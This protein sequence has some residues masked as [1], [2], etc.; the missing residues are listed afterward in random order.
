MPEAVFARGGEFDDEPEPWYKQHWAGLRNGI[1]V[2]SWFL[3]GV[4]VTMKVAGW[5][6]VTACYV[7]TQIVTTIGYGDMAIPEDLH[8]FMTIY[9][10][11][12]IAIVA[13]VVNDIFNSI[14]EKGTERMRAKLRKFESQALMEDSDG[15]DVDVKEVYGA[16]NYFVASFLFFLFFLILGATFY[17]YYESCTCS[18][19]VST[20][21]GCI[22]GELC[23]TT[24]GSTKNWSEC[25]YMAV[26]TMVTVGFGDYSPTSWGGRIFGVYWMI[27]GVLATANF[28]GSIGHLLQSW[29]VQRKKRTPAFCRELFQKIDVNQNGVLSRAEFIE[30]VLVKENLV[31][32]ED[33]SRVNRVF[34]SMDTNKTGQLEYSSLHAQFMDDDAEDS[35]LG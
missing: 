26:I 33:L 20:I 30:W 23:Y 1:F 21:E 35:E 8:I 16:T 28:I 10:L 7:I 32:Q 18:Y 4:G 9:V 31:S 15:D 2:V 5:S 14:L 25:I 22:E 34:D 3:V 13:S 12:G 17:R 24:G 29:D 6:F 27:L 11:F 19:G